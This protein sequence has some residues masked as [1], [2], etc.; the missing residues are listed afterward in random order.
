MEIFKSKLNI[1]FLGKRYFAY[2]LSGL[3][4][5][6]TLVLLVV[7]GG[8]NYGVDFTGGVVIQVKLE[9]K[10]IPSEIREALAGTELED[11]I[12]QEFGEAGAFEYL[13]RLTNP[14]IQ[15]A[16]LGEKTQKA[17]SEKLGEKVDI[18]QVEMVGPQ[19]GKELRE[20]ALYAIFYALLIMAVYISGRFE[21]K[22]LMAI[23]MAGC[24]I[25]ATSFAA[26]L[27]VGVLWL[28][29]IALFV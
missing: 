6:A 1:D 18:R 13:I 12:I 25:A 7:R 10:H 19:V 4:I 2:T 23:I 9:K 22:W 27:G 15:V 20:K 28:I 24:L 17:L 5:L 14:D 16:G 21:H 8:P 29:F 11:C 3:C 26:I